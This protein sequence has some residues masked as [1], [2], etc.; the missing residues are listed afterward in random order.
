[1]PP[2]PRLSLLSPQHGQG[3]DKT[4]AT[5]TTYCAVHF[6]SWALLYPHAV[7]QHD[8]RAQRLVHLSRLSGLPIELN[9]HPLLFALSTNTPTA[10]LM[11]LVTA[12]S[13]L[14]TFSSIGC[15]SAP[16]H[17]SAP[18]VCTLAFFHKGNATPFWSD[19]PGRPETQVGRWHAMR[20]RG[21]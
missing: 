2:R 19:I 18:I 5:S 3:S 1:M 6:Q 12:L 15:L 8:P 20:R 17:P 7:V 13:S 4:G 16:T 10:S 14:S 11:P 9:A 21:R